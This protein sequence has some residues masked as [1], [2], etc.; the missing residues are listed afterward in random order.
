[1]GKFEQKEETCWTKQ[2][3]CG[4]SKGACIIVGIFLFIFIGGGIAGGIAAGV[5]LTKSAL[6]IFGSALSGLASS[7]SDY[8]DPSW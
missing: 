1:M 2:C 8:I 7:Q 6:G 3:C 5:I 4:C